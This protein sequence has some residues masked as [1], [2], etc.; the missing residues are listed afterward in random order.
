[1]SCSLTAHLTPREPQCRELI[2][3]DPG[4]DRLHTDHRPGG[5]EANAETGQA[6]YL[7]PW[8]S[9]IPRTPGLRTPGP[10]PCTPAALA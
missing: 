6:R 8:P 10:G 3:H 5:L 4:R 7:P 9:T 1:M 2:F